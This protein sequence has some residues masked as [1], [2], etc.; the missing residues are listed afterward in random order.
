MTQENF[1]HEFDPTSSILFLGAGFS[2]S[3]TNLIGEGPPVGDDL[4][5]KIK[6]LSQLPSDDPSSFQDLST[7]AVKQGKDLFTLLCNL[8]TIKKLNP[9]QEI[10]L[11]QQWLRIYT[12]NYDDAVEFFCKS[13]NGFE[14]RHTYS[15]ESQVPNQFRPGSI[16]H[17]HGYIHECTRENLLRQLVLSHHSY[18]QQRAVQSPWWD[19]FERDVRVAKNIF[20]V[21]YDLKDFEP[22]KYLTQNPRAVEKTHFIL[23]STQS[24]V[25][26]SRLD[27]YG[28]RD[29]MGV[30]GFAEECKACVVSAKPEHANVLSAFRFIEL[31]KDDKVS[32]R[33]S[34]M[35][36]QSLFA[37]GKFIL[38]RLLLTFPEPEYTIPRTQSLEHC[39][40]ALGGCR[41]LLLHSKIG[42]GKT[43][44]K[45][46]L[47]IALTQQGHSCFE[48]RE[49]VTP[50]AEEID[51]IATQPKPVVFFPDY[52]TAYSNIHLFSDLN[53]DARFV[54]EILTG[55]LQVRHSEV[56]NR[57]PKPI[58]RA[59][60]NRLNADDCKAIY[61][62][63]DE[64][65]IA[66]SDFIS[67]YGK[68]AEMRDIVLSV[69]ENVSVIKRIDSLVQPILANSEAKVVLFCSAILKALGVHT[70][71]GFLRSI[72]GV[73]SY[74]VLCE[75]GEGAYEFVD[76]ALDRIEPH[77]ALFSEF[78]IKRYLKPQELVGA[79]F[80]MASEAARR[81]NENANPQSER[82]RSA[83]ATLGALLR[84]SFLDEL[85]HQYPERDQYIRDVYE[86]GRRDTY[87]QGEPLFWL[88]YS[89][90]MQDI[91]NWV[92]AERHME[93]AY[94]RGAARPGFL[95]YQLDTNSL[96][97]CLDLE[98]R[99]EK[100][101]QVSRAE[102][103]LELLDKAREM[104]G[105][106][107]HRGHTLKVLRSLEPFLQHR[108]PGLSKAEGVG[109]VYK[110]NLIIDVLE[111]LSVDEKAE[112]G[113]R[114]V[115][116]ILKRAL[117]ILTG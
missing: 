53:Q 67:K 80:R 34:P 44:F 32:S 78:L 39:I 98:L 47:A 19:V 46:G 107:N 36:I 63:L 89:I 6:D 64:A 66:P 90:F 96:G 84:F 13:T 95:T 48:L 40:T 60:L 81:M 21:G 117:S 14:N 7:Y 41:T 70:D 52:D 58:D 92:L 77:S 2:A 1:P 55:T 31:L 27:E 54:V 114:D 50:P 26:E 73:D 22:A 37:F 16:V 99:A 111:N 88:Q 87:I 56:F 113:T 91:G 109:F 103:I 49:K 29:S 93:T 112:W 45:H 83:R 4:G 82:A 61:K 35:E 86:H 97:L 5:N 69:F 28:R 30:S 59:N 106:G 42:N 85:L 51:F 20:F 57:L 33:P 3:A 9:D 104:I 15:T 108:A 72:S 75:T 17:L 100:D 76:F 115:E 74:Q 79:V 11:S 110:I 105:D 25:A 102:Q 18:A 38:Q 68:G 65:G 94:Q 8:Y 116:E 101:S 62:L 12:T 10:I 43:I 23:R 24:P 71:P